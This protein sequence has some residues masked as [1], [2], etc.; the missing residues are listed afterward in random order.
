MSSPIRPSRIAF[1][2]ALAGLGILGFIYGNSSEVWE[3]IPKSLPGRPLVMYLCSLVALASGLALVLRPLTALACRVLLPFL[4]LWL[5]LLKLPALLLAP[6]A[7]VGWESFA[8]TAALAAG[9]WCLF[10]AHAGPWERRHLGFTVGERGIRAARALLIAALPMI[11]VSHFVY[12]DLTAS[13]VPK[14]LG[15]SLGWT[16]LTGAASLAAAAGM[17]LGVLARLAASLE[18]AML[19]IFTLLVWV[20][21]VAS[22]PHDQGNW[23]ELLISAAI[24]GGA[25]LV[26]ETYRGVPWLA[27]GRAARPTTLG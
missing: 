27:S 2:A 11:G 10:A 26:A 8:E 25:W 21:R 18:A 14:W 3:P 13:L 23:S 5:V 1:A 6:R 20:P 24:A 9:G 22:G 7:V 19:W 16:Y 12:H 17:L 15:F 4:L